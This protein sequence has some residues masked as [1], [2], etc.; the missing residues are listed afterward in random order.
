MAILSFNKIKKSY[1]FSL[2]K[3]EK[4]YTKKNLQI[5]LFDLIFI[6]FPVLNLLT[7]LDKDVIKRYNRINIIL[8]LF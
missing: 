1:K 7:E 2:N 5:S 3:F 8:K 6:K 4:Y